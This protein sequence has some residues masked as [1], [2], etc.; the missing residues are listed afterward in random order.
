VTFCAVVIAPST[1]LTRCEIGALDPTHGQAA[2]A[3]AAGWVTP[4]TADIV[5]AARA[6]ATATMRDL[7]AS[8]D[9]RDP[10]GL[11]KLHMVPPRMRPAAQ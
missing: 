8:D 1:S 6:A 3:A 2:E 4:A 5:P 10:D 11:R 7:F 9:G